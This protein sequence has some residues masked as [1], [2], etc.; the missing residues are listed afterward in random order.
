MKKMT[1]ICGA[2][3]A[4]CGSMISHAPIIPA[5]E[6]SK[7]LGTR[8]TTP[9]Q[10]S[11]VDDGSGRARFQFVSNTERPSVNHTSALSLGE[12]GVSPSL[13][14]ESRGDNEL[15]R[16]NRA[17]RPMDLVT[18][19]IAENSEG[20]K[21]ADTEV[22]SQST[23]QV[24]LEKLFGYETDATKSR[25][26]LDP[27]ALVQGQVQND[28][29]GEGRT[30]RRGALRA[31]ISAMVAEVLPSGILRVEGQKI[32]SVNNEEQVLVIS[33]LVRPR[34]M[35][36]ENEVD[37]RKVANMRIDFFGQG[38]IGEAQFGGWLGRILRVIWPF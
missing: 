9:Y 13:W 20:S 31:T 18:I 3:L 24:A 1:L 15:F 35:S 19:V 10:G 29:K 26:N 6:Y 14:N 28:F 30:N 37:S 32:I 4:G 5:V 22:K 33:G 17:W 38:S 16:D 36:S 8:T 27:A 7:M 34:D 11:I 12:S 25:P 21:S 23:I 2:L